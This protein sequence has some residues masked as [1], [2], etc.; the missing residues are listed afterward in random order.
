LINVHYIFENNLI[1]VWNCVL[2][3][4]IKLCSNEQIIRTRHWWLMPVIPAT[5]EAEIRRITVQNQ[6]GEIIQETLL[7]KNPS[8]KRAGGVAQ[9]VG[10]E[11][12][13]QCHKKFF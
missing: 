6:P 7:P 9:S 5:Q 13:P 12:K 11:F 8:Q 3:I 1:D 4:S 10:P 2:N